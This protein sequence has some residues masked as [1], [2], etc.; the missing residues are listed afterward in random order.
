MTEYKSRIYNE[1]G[2]ILNGG[3][4]PIKARNGHP[5]PMKKGKPPP[6]CRNFH[7]FYEPCAGSCA[8]LPCSVIGEEWESRCRPH[9]MEPE[10]GEVMAEDV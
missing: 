4:G 10:D 2:E 3:G 5:I 1:M 9:H 6:W 8:K 7:V